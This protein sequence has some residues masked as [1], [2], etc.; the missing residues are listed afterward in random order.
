MRLK[1]TGT[2]L[3]VITVRGIEVNNALLQLLQTNEQRGVDLKSK[4][5][6]VHKYTHV[7]II[8]I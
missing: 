4:C 1:Q 5:M 6:Y 3:S 2:F 7:H 8:Y